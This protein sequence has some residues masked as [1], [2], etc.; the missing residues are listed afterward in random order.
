MPLPMSFISLCKSYD[1]IILCLKHFF[2][3]YHRLL[4]YIF[5]FFAH[6]KKICLS[7]LNFIFPGFKILS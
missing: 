7:F 1:V 5:S 2:E 3:I 4:Q 6:L